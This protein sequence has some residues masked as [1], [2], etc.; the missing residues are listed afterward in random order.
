MLS[1]ATL[2]TVR[3]WTTSDFGMI[4]A[5]LGRQEVLS[6][7]LALFKRT[8]MHTDLVDYYRNHPGF[9]GGGALAVPPEVGFKSIRKMWPVHTRE[10]Q[11]DLQ[12]Q[13]LERCESHR[14]GAG[15]GCRELFMVRSLWRSHRD[16]VLVR[17]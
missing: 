9:V 17:P 13:G 11:S 10:I 8:W 6:E 2:G 5:V 16:S 3:G 1:V 4:L 7:R 15:T 12:G 14:G